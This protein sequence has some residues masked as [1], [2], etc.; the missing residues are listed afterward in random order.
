MKQD[1]QGIINVVNQKGNAPELAEH[2]INEIRHLYKVER[3]LRESDSSPEKRQRIRRVKAVPILKRF[4]KWLEANRGLP[5]S[6]WGKAVYYSLARW[7]KLCRYTEDG[8]IEI[9]T[10]LVENTIRPIAVGR[11]YGQRSIM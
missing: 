2:A 10:N 7:E 8:R 4:K 1:G 5:K 9:D 11:R 6:P 3:E